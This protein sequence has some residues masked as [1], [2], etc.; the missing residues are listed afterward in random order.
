MSKLLNMQFKLLLCSYWILYF[1]IYQCM[2]CYPSEEGNYSLY[3]SQLL[4]LSVYF[5][6]DHLLVSKTL[7]KSKTLLRYKM[8]NFWPH[9]SSYCLT[10]VYYHKSNIPLI[11]EKVKQSLSYL[12]VTRER[13]LR[14]VYCAFLCVVWMEVNGLFWN[15]SVSAW[16]CVSLPK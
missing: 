11:I 9:I 3:T 16:I 6:C 7:V 13:Y 5:M 12:W 4:I 10:S 2:S 1:H 15:E 8:D 14:S